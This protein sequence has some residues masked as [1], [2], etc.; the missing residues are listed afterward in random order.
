MA[1]WEA[2]CAASW[3]HHALLKGRALSRLTDRSA[4]TGSAVKAAGT[5]VKFSMIS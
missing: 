4:S 3:Q 5:S 2:P 1:L